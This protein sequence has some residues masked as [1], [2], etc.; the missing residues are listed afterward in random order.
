MISNTFRARGLPVA[1]SMRIRVCCGKGRNDTLRIL[2]S[3]FS[4]SVLPVHEDVPPPEG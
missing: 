2:S 3:L 4:P 1:L